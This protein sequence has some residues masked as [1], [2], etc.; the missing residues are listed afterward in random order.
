MAID[1]AS[2][3]TAKEL[4]DSVGESIPRLVRLATDGGVAE[5]WRATAHLYLAWAQPLLSLIWPQPV[6]GCDAYEYPTPLPRD[7]VVKVAVLARP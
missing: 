3:Q 2:G 7:S 5:L 1:A 6:P 4:R